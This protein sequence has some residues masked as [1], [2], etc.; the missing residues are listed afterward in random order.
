MSMNSNV[1][2]WQISK[3][4]VVSDRG[5]VASQN[6][7]AA[8][9]GADA[10]A[11]GGNAIDAAVACAFALYALE[12][13]TC[14]MG[15]SGYMVIWLASEKRATVIDF[16]GTL[17]AAID[18]ADYPLDPN[19]PD[20]IMGFP[21]VV[22]NANV[23]GYRSITIPGAVAGLSQAQQQHG[24]LG[25][26]TVI[27]P[28]IA[29]A[30]RGL[31][32]NWYTTLQIALEASDLLKYPSSAAIYLPGG[33]PAKPEQYLS[34]GHLA[35]TL[36]TLAENG[37][38]EFYQGRIAELLAAD[39]QA[40]GSRITVDDL[41][42]Y[43]PQVLEPLMGHHRNATLY[44]AGENSGGR[45]LNEALEYVDQHLDLKQAIGAHTYAIYAKA[46]NKAF[47][48]HKQRLG[49]VITTGCTSHM[50]AVDS[51]GNMVAL[52]YTLLNR[53]GS[54]V[55]LPATGVLM[56][57]SVSYFDPRPGFATTMEGG[58]RINSS[59]MCP[60]L[61]VRDGEAL[62]AVGASG[63]DHIVP[64]TMQLTALL[65][66]YGISLEA[67]FALPRIDASGRDSIRVD[68]AMGEEAVAILQAEFAV[69]IA[70]NLVFPKLY[71]CPSGVYRDI[72]SG[73]TYG[74]SDQ[75]NPVAGA[76]AEARFVVD[77][78]LS[79]KGTSVCA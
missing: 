19:V 20:S 6:A 78:A 4:A 74:C 52:T 64:C 50:S 5:I 68:P 33:G 54:K 13:W 25:F 61:C 27:S 22:K 63:A 51:E 31:P 32:V 14:G 59:N 65:L 57:N 62:F 24:D 17:P 66:D 38:G 67:A 44:T 45:R 37:P 39:L 11:R 47:T 15:G 42:V 23:L 56:N 72:K 77:N 9:A 70:Q 48:S 79:A 2:Q 60:T 29:L 3:R 58:K 10:L 46:L 55:V 30:E 26:D 28:A 16:Q 36:R 53:F 49:K 69:E 35:N 12:P 21:G 34:L 73:K 40:G 71:A 1:E 41:A 8:A 76:A 75:S 7:M 43:A 18:P